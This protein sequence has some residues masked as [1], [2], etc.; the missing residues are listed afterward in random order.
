MASPSSSRIG[1]NKTQNILL[2]NL[3]SMGNIENV[4]NSALLNQLTGMVPMLNSSHH[5]TESTRAKLLLEALQNKASAFMREVSAV[6]IQRLARGFM[7]RR[8]A[9]RQRLVTSIK[10]SLSY[11]I[12]ELLLDEILVG[13]VILMARGL[14]G[15]EISIR[16]VEEAREQNVQRALETVISAELDVQI[17]ALVRVCIKEEA[18]DFINRRRKAVKNPLLRLIFDLT[19]ETVMELLPDVARSA[20]SD[21]VAEFLLERRCEKAFGYICLDMFDD[22]FPLLLEESMAEAD[23]EIAYDGVVTDVVTELLREDVRKVV[24]SSDSAKQEAVRQDDMKI[25]GEHLIKGQ[26][27]RMLLGHLMMSVAN[28]FEEVLLEHQ[29]R[30]VVR[31][32]MAHRLLTL[33]TEGSTSI[34]SLKESRMSREAYR[35]L[36]MGPIQELAIDA[37]V[38]ASQHIMSEVDVL[39]SRLAGMWAR[40]DGNAHA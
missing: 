40:E 8:K 37:M 24:G 25:I 1:K 33:V 5:E 17:P 7:G 30:C 34:T 31:R 6:R 3:S 20:V 13:E 9:T 15:R 28:N 4:P 32:F 2:N 18:N 21:C 36:S 39:E 26:A 22:D 38:D 29:S 19:D 23:L 10:A 27:R 12:T 14:L 11:K 16:N 35:A